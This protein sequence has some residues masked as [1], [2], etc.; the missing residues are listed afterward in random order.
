MLTVEQNV[1]E[2]SKLHLT[3]YPSPTKLFMSR[4]EAGYM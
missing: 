4:D 3:V 1:T 2:G